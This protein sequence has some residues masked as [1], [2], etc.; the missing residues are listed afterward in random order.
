VIARC[1]YGVDLNPLAVDLCKLALWI[2]GH[3]AGM[4]LSFLDSHIRLGNSL[5]GASSD[6]VDAGIPDDAFKPVS[7]DTKQVASALRKRNKQERELFE[8]QQ[9]AQEDMFAAPATAPTA[10]LAA[11]LRALDQTPDSD[12]AT[13]HAKARRYAELREQARAQFV[14]YDLWTAAFFQPLAADAPQ[15][16]THL[17]LDHQRAPLPFDHP[18]VL[19]AHL[20][21]HAPELRFFHW[22]LEFPPVFERGGFDVVL[23]NPPWERIKLQEQEHFVDVPEIRNARNKAERDKLIRAWRGS[24]DP[25]QRERIAAFERAKHRAEASSRFVRA[26][27]RYPLTAVG[28]VNTV[29]PYCE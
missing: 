24:D 5:V 11:G 1:I 25:A 13:I 20:L 6:L 9:M 23:G 8:R 7:G 22:E 17:L 28:D 10:D 2:E 4:P 14:L 26:S 21:A 12:V 19:A 29:V 27:G 16:T 15:M 3:N 18:A